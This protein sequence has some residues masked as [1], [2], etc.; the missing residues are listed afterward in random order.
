MATRPPDALTSAWRATSP[1]R[2]DNPTSARRSTRRRDLVAD[3]NPVTRL[4]LVR[5][6]EKRGHAVVVATNGREAVAAVEHDTF[7]VV[8]MDIQM[9]ELGGVQA[10]AEI[11]RPEATG[12]GHVIMIA[13]TA[14]AMKGDRERFLE[15]G[16][17]GY[18][19]KPVRPADLYRALEGV[20]HRDG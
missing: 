1:S 10:P 14:H 20:P 11:R 7:D 4:L 15:A 5:L 2:C 18:L 9:P 12:G 8:L 19:S 6:L 3:D 17:D 16:M 13:L